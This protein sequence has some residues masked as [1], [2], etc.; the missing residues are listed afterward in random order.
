VHEQSRPQKGVYLFAR[1]KLLMAKPI[2][3]LLRKETVFDAK[4]RQQGEES[5]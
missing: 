1:D 4:E 3:F 5:P 2:S